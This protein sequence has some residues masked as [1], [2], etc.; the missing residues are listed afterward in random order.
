MTTQHI[1]VDLKNGLQLKIEGTGL[2]GYYAFCNI[3]FNK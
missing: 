1:K 2:S 3:T